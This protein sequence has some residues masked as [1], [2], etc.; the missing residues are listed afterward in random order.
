MARP[1]FKIE[2]LPE[3]WKTI[4]IDMMSEGASDAEVCA[5]FNIP[6]SAHKRFLS[7]D[8][9]YSIFYEMAKTLSEAWWSKEGRVNLANR[10]FNNRM[11]SINM[12]NRFNWNFSEPAK[13]KRDKPEPRP[14]STASEKTLPSEGELMNKYSIA[15]DDKTH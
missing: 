8:D 11:W 12:F 9:E 5:K 1:G 2:D 7:Q 6:K 3:D 15:K 10:N 13:P 14:K 4:M